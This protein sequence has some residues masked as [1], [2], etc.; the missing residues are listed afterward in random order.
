MVGYVKN[1]TPDITNIEASM[2]N[3]Q[4]IRDIS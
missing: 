3:H 1:I 2:D 4:S